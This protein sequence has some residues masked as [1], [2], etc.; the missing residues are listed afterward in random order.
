MPQVPEV[1]IE[2][3]GD[4]E[5]VI[6]DFDFPY[7][8]QAE[9]FV[10]VDG[11]QTPYVWVGG[12]THTIQV[13][14]APAEDTKVVIFRST[15]AYV[16]KHLFAGGVPFLP[17]YVDENNR[18]MLYVL[19]EGVQN[20]AAVSDSVAE[21]Y[22]AA[23][24]AQLSADEAARSATT[25][26]AAAEHTLRTPLDEPVVPT[27]PGASSRANRLLGFDAVGNPTLVGAPS[28][29]AAELALDLA[30]TVDPNKGAALIGFG[31]GHTVADLRQATSLAQGAALLGNGV[32]SVNSI[33][34]L[35][36]APLRTDLLYSVHGYLGGSRRGGGHFVYVP[37]VARTLHDGGTVIS[38]TVPFNGTVGAVPAFVN[39]VGETAPG[40]FGC[41]VRIYEELRGEDFGMTGG[42]A[43]DGTSFGKACAVAAALKVPLHLRG[44]YNV[45][46]APIMT[47][48]MT[49]VGHG[50]T[51]LTGNLS[52]LCQ[53]FRPAADTL[54]PLNEDDP[55]F[56]AE[57]VGFRA[58]NDAFG[59]AVEAQYGHSFLDTCTL[60]DCTFYGQLGFRGVH[61]IGGEVTGCLFY[62]TI[63]GVKQEGSTNWLYTECRWRQAAR[64]GFYAAVNATS[65]GR[66]GG[67]NHKFVG[68]EWAVCTIG[69][70][71]E[72]SMWASFESCLFDYCNLP[73]FCVGAMY[74]KL[75]KTYLG[76]ADVGS[77]RLTAG[78]TAAPTT[79][80]ALYCIPYIDG[81][82]VEPFSWT[83]VDCE[84]VN[85]V[86]GADQPVINSTGYSASAPTSR[87]SQRVQ[88]ANCKVL[89]AAMHSALQLV[90]IAY[91][92]SYRGRDTVF[93]SFNKSTTLAAPLIL[94]NVDEWAV[95]GT[96][97]TA[98][99]QSN[100]RMFS[101]Y[102]RTDLG[103]LHI[104]DN[105]NGLQI[106]TRDGTGTSMVV[107]GVGSD[108]VDVYVGGRLVNVGQGLVNSGG[109]G[110]RALIVPN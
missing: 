7:Q 55:Y 33:A 100:V 2:F 68:C 13:T 91:C 107:R 58:V 87:F 14:P 96:D 5:T 85:Y 57:G 24:A 63:A 41:L 36:T 38:P 77:L 27:L 108:R 83:A 62:T 84:F 99:Y 37:S 46:G 76:A 47:G 86:A 39:A 101:T 66:K 60:T 6:F 104:V 52:Y 102:E 1:S 89:Q 106:K 90:S 3:R 42:N 59:L 48:R 28:G 31:A 61:L 12:S 15:L 9:V 11:V 71:L 51:T 43:A 81:S 19:Q 18:Q 53:T 109:A 29:S 34:L 110:Y 17:R 103:A 26:V 50:R 22:A 40:A 79:G 75:S 105:A 54:D 70:K 16:P 93:D 30:N 80:T 10:T 69:V 74:L 94:N 64:Y 95:T 67:E 44:R 73:M 8:S 65:P 97:T 35:L 32:V 98:C 45:V 56:R 82:N 23:Y 25:A 72:R 21:A 92:T 49:L 4:G 78:Y 20:F 88:M